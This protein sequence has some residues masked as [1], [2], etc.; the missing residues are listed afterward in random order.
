MYGRLGLGL[1]IT[2]SVCVCVR[3]NMRHAIQE[4]TEKN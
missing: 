1:G 2:V 4:R 3:V